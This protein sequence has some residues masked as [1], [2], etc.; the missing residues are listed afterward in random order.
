MIAALQQ[1]VLLF[2]GLGLLWWAGDRAV[3]YAVEFTDI[4]GITS[5]TVGFLIMSVSTGLPEI[6]TAIITVVEDAAPLSAGN[7]IGSSLVNLSLVLG[8]SAVAAGTM[9]VDREEERSLLKILAVITV[10][11]SLIF[12]TSHL[13]MWHGALLV[14]TYIGAVWMLK[15]GGLMRKIVREETAA[16]T[17]EHAAETFLAGPYG[18]GLK[19]LGSLAFVIVGAELTVSSALSLTEVIG[20]SMEAMGATIVAVGTGLPEITLE[21]NAVKRKEYALA[22]GDIFGSTLVNLALVLGFLSLLNPAP[23]DTLPLVGTVLYLG[24]TILYIWKIALTDREIDRRE[25]LVLIIL[26]LAYLVEEIGVFAVLRP[27]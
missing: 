10:L 7:L 8:L 23:I 1:W 24:V 21:L 12:V 15:R 9:S 11:V 2:A 27:A 22:L 13:T 18:T 3:R 5:F 19:F 14:G 6:V 17:E 26:F 20:L 4:F 16:A 25:G